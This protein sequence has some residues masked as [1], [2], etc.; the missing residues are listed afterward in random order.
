MS[1]LAF[2]LFFVSFPALLLNLIGVGRFVDDGK[3]HGGYADEAPLLLGFLDKLADYQ[4]NESAD[5]A[6]PMPNRTRRTIAGV[7]VIPAVIVIVVRLCCA[8]FHCT[9]RLCLRR[10]RVNRFQV[11]L[12]NAVLDRRLQIHAAA[13]ERICAPQGAHHKVGNV[14]GMALA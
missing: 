14:F 2:P 10:F 12:E 1:A 4:G 3:C 11:L 13:G 8:R 5:G 7:M 6:R 9:Q